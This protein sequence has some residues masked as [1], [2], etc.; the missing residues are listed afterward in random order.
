MLYALNTS[1]LP[2]PESGEATHHMAEHSLGDAWQA[3]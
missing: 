3:G 1:M 2:L